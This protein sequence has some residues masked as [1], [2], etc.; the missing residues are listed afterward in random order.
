MS[1]I[2]WSKNQWLSI[3]MIWLLEKL[4]NKWALSPKTAIVLEDTKYAVQTINWISS[5]P[6]LIKVKISGWWKYS[7]Y[8]TEEWKRRIDGWNLMVG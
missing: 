4:D 1:E 6:K 5:V 3:E 8:L 7:I 2:Q